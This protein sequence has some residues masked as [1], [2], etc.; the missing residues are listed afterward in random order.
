MAEQLLDSAKHFVAE[1]ITHMKKPEADLTWVSV[2][3]MD[4]EAV[5]FQS[6]VEITNPYSHDIPVC[7]ISYRLKS[8]NREIASGN[9]P[10]PGFVKAKE[11]TVIKIPSKVPYSFVLSL[12]R[13]VSADWDIDYEMDIELIVDL[14][15]IGNF[16]I[17][18]W[19]KGTLKLPTLF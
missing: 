4:R 15:I 7:E 6:D 3:G 13:D 17:P 14:P 16:K 9:I 10:D 12:L 1:K 5:V 2:K 11:K 8:A 18:A 19:K